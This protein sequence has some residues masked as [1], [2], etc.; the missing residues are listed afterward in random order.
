MPAALPTHEIRSFVRRSPRMN[1]SQERAWAQYRA[2]YLLDLPPGASETLLAE[3]AR[4]DPAEAFPGWRPDTPLIVEIGPGRGDSL[5]AMA[6]ARPD[7]AIL[8]FE[9]YLPALASL[10]RRLAAA[11]LH[12]VRLAYCDGVDGL[13]KLVPDGGLAEL[14]TFFPDPWRK[15]RHHKRRLVNPGFA[16]L[17]VAKL[18]P[19]GRWRLATDWPD[20]AHHMREVLDT[21][22]GLLNESPDG[23]ASR[24]DRPPT[25]FE[26][27]GLADGRPVFDLSYRRRDDV[28]A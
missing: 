4:F 26:Q 25:K 3:D 6:A 24:A 27:R 15:T 5:V 14:W 21:H 12:N 22:P 10:V 8:A 9:V 1:P 2:R 16:D 19:G 18:R 17:V 28:R 20:Y 11:D 7:A 13:A 23:W